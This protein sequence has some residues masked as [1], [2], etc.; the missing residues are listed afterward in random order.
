MLLYK[1]CWTRY[2]QQTKALSFQ[3]N[4]RLNT[5]PWAEP[6]SFTAVGPIF[7]KGAL[8]TP[9]IRQVNN[10]CLQKTRYSTT[11]PCHDIVIWEKDFVGKRQT[12]EIGLRT[13]TPYP[14]NPKLM[15]PCW[16]HFRQG[17]PLLSNMYKMQGRALPG[18]SVLGAMIPLEPIHT[19]HF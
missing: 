6:T 5:K 8:R 12:A 7:R 14:L 15:S 13:Q 18:L 17:S 11:A 1:P 2:F 9:H 16:T 19:G 3:F 4:L 10:I